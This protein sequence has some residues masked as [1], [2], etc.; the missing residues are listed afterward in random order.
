MT[1]PSGYWQSSER[2]PSSARR[3]AIGSPPRPSDRTKELSG[4][5]AASARR[6]GIGDVVRQLF[7]L[8][9]GASS[10]VIRLPHHATGPRCSCRHTPQAYSVVEISRQGGT[11]VGSTGDPRGRPARG[12]SSRSRSSTCWGCG[13][14]PRSSSIPSSVSSARSSIRADAIGGHA[15][16][17]RLGDPASRPGLGS[18]VRDARRGGGRRRRVRHRARLRVADQLVPERA[19]Q[20]VRDHRPRGADLPVDQSRDR[21]DADG[22]DALH[23]RRSARLPS[24]RR[25]SGAPGPS[26][27]DGRGPSAGPRGPE[28]EGAWGLAV[29]A[30]RSMGARHVA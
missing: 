28:G 19:G 4:E 2:R 17:V 9:P 8:P 12:G 24:V 5:P 16:S 6:P 7:P 15:R 1:S 11:D 22:C 21:L 29:D 30:T 10:F 13:R 26:G 18:A 27:R 25:R 14:S 23:R 3:T 20:R